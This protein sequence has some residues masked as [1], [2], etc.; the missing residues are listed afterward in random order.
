MKNQTQRSNADTF[1]N[2][3]KDYRFD[4]IPTTRFASL[5]EPK[6]MKS[7]NIIVSRDKEA[8]NGDSE[9]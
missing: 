6:A 8:V 2:L 4:T 5:I 9:E 1:A 3:I 7:M